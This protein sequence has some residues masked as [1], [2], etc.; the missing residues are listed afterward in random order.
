MVVSFIS[1]THFLYHRVYWIDRI[2]NCIKRGNG[3]TN[4]IF[5]FCMKMINEI[6]LE[7]FTHIISEDRKYQIK[8]TCRSYNVLRSLLLVEQELLTLPE[9]T[10]SPPVFS[11]VRVTRSL[12]LCVCFVDRWLSFCLFSFGH[13]FV[14]SSSIYRFW[15]PLSY[16]ETI[17]ARGP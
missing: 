6:L 10:S 14:C 8:P 9:H 11:G 3:W 17:L 12:V 1:Q 4:G 16:L 2:F 15:W 7:P 5:P 13:G